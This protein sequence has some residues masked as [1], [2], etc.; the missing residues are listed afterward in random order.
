[1]ITITRDEYNRLEMEST[2]YKK[3]LQTSIKLKSVIIKYQELV[4][5][6]K[7]KN[8][9]LE[10]KIRDQRIDTNKQL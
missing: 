9:F 8:E 5:L 2:K 4:K 10:K 6:E 7:E 3:I 1:M